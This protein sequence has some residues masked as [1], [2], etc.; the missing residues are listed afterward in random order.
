ME[1]SEQIRKLRF[2][3]REELAEFVIKIYSSDETKLKQ[4]IKKITGKNIHKPL[5]IRIS[6]FQRYYLLSGIILKISMKSYPLYYH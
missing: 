1:N 3:P 6:I 2:L 4:S 5:K